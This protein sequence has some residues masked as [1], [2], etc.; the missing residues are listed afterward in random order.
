MADESTAPRV[1][2]LLPPEWDGVALDAL[3][4]FPAGLNFVM[5]RWNDG[6]V[7]ARGMHG[8]GVMV[9]HPA[10]T[11]AF[12]TFNAHVATCSL[13]RRIREILILRLSW[14]RRAEY[15]YI[16]HVV[17]GQRAGI[18]DEELE[19][20]Q[21]GPDAAGWDPEDADLVRAVDELHADARISDATWARLSARFSSTELIDLVFVV[22]CYDVLAMVFKTFNVPL[23]PGVAELEPEVRAR[24][25][26][27]KRMADS[28]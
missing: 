5:S 28:G 8:L 19:R 26:A 16:Q 4:A 24:M 1:K 25:H 23:E 13:S 20:L 21:I 27:K 3:G 12:L 22:G 18:T 2:P 17:L 7:D 15:E 14:L 6:G 11:K 10:A 9:Q